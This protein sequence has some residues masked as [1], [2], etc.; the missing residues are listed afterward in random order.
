VQDRSRYVQAGSIRGHEESLLHNQDNPCRNRWRFRPRAGYL[1]GQ[2]SQCCGL[3]YLWTGIPRFARFRQRLDR[4]ATANHSGDF[5]TG[6]AVYSG[7]LLGGNTSGTFS[8]GHAYELEVAA[9]YGSGP[10]GLQNLIPS[11]IENLSTSFS[12]L[13]GTG[14]AGAFTAEVVTVPGTSS[15]GADTAEF[16]IFAWYSGNSQYTSY[17]AAI[18]AGVMSGASDPFSGTTEGAPALPPVLVNA[19]SFNLT[20][21]VPTPE[22]DTLVLGLVGAS[23]FLLRRLLAK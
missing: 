10:V 7:P 2:G 18:A 21:P 11:T 15:T 19:R 4:L 23:T 5:P 9:V 20:G 6:T 1:D 22:P 8:N 17:G 3:S 13:G 12:T 14:N 16:Q